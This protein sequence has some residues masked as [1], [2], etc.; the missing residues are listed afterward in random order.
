MP[1]PRAGSP[2][3]T[4]PLYATFREQWTQLRDVYEGDGG[5]LDPNRPYLIPHPREWDDH[6]LKVTNTETQQVGWVPNPNP[7]IASAKLK[8]R[9]KIARYENF[10]ATIFEGIAGALFRDAPVRTFADS[11]KSRVGEFWRNADGLGNPV[12]GVLQSAW[13]MAG[14]M[15]HAVVTVD[16]EAEPVAAGQT[17]SLA[18]T[19]LPYLCAYSA[20]DLIDWLVDERGRLLA[21]KLLE[22]APRASLDA[23]PKFTTTDVRVRV[24]DDVNWTLY[25][26]TGKK[27]DGGPHGMG[28][29]PVEI[30]YGK[31]RTL[32]S[33]VGK[34]IL[35]DPMLYIDLY[36]LISETR[37]LLRNQ[38]FALLNIP[39]G[40]KSPDEEKDKIGQSG[41]TGSILFSSQT[42]AYISPQATNAEAYNEHIDRLKRSIYRLAAMPWETDSKDAEA[43]GSLKVKREDMNRV[44]AGYASELAR[45]DAG[46][47]DLVYRALV[48]PERA[49]A[50][51]A[52]EKPTTAYPKTFDVGIV[53]NAIK[54][55]TDAIALDLG[56]TAR[57]ELKKR[58]ARVALP[59]VAKETLQVID[60]EID[61]LVPAG[62]TA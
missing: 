38:T 61:A 56:Q 25:D 37:E 26:H 31:R 62:A 41:G 16:S 59:D 18:D 34:S 13:T 48:G 58:A 46:L 57:R 14:V 42:A 27:I 29:L 20:L 7:R 44:L 50:E 36:N 45:V 40:D 53:E 15:G 11:V 33:V 54:N 51:R 10:A 4:H 30:L 6:S 9:R 24:L 47:T 17:R 32:T 12:D 52:R 3:I 22:L 43:E 28:R 23:V 39:I 8:A 5:F 60:E 55:A 35:G 2:G 49:E 19:P 21:V 1:K